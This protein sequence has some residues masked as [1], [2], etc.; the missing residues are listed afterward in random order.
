M[1]SKG[2]NN[3]HPFGTKLHVLHVFLLVSAVKHSLYFSKQNVDT[4]SQ[5]HSFKNCFYIRKNFSSFSV[6]TTA[7]KGFHLIHFLR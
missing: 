5:G 3:F 4:D 6:G 7:G 2:K 1:K